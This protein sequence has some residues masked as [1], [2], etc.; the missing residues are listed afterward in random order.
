MLKKD[1][2]PSWKEELQTLKVNNMGDKKLPRS[3]ENDYTKEMAEKRRQ[4]IQEETGA[5]L[6]H[7]GQFSFDPEVTSGNIENFS[8]VAQ[9]PKE[10]QGLFW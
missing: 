9:I 2:N 7:L 5:D 6:N 4:F 1:F 10:W 3:R 8:G